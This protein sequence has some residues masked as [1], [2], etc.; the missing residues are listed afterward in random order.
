M[1]KSTYLELA[2]VGLMLIVLFFIGNLPAHNSMPIFQ[3]TSNSSGSFFTISL[4]SISATF[5]S[6]TAGLVSLAVFCKYIKDLLEAR[7]WKESRTPVVIK[8]K[9]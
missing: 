1:Q 5:A 6:I 7:K 3:V 2:F 4:D 8:V 9:R